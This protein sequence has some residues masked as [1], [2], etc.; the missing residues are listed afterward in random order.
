MLAL[1]IRLGGLGIFD[2]RKSPEDNYYF[3]VSF[4][5]PLAAAIINQHSSFDCAIFHCQRDLNQEAFSIKHQRLTDSLSTFSST[6]PPNLQLP[7]KLAGEKGASSWLSTLPLECH[8]FALHKGDF[9]D[10]VALRY[11]WPPKNLPVFVASLTPLN[12]L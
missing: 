7:L 3:S 1:P 6:L 11:G 4:T 12:M 10:D 9:C 2:P 5:S 8:G